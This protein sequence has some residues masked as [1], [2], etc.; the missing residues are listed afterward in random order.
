MVSSLA[1]STQR[2]APYTNDLKFCTRVRIVLR[3]ILFFLLCQIFVRTYSLIELVGR[4]HAFL[5]AR[6]SQNFSQYLAMVYPQIFLKSHN[7][8]RYTFLLTT[9]PLTKSQP[10]ESK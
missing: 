9:A 4:M 6:F 10:L 1:S 5:L 8:R 7:I 3:G 2:T